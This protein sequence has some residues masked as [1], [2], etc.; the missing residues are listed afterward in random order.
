MLCGRMI[1]GIDKECIAIL[2]CNWLTWRK[3]AGFAVGLLSV[4]ALAEVWSETWLFG[5]GTNVESN[6]K[7][8]KQSL[9]SNYFN[10]VYSSPS[11]RPMFHST[12]VKLH[13]RTV[14]VNACLREM[15]RVLKWLQKEI[16]ERALTI[17]RTSVRGKQRARSPVATLAGAEGGNCIL[18]P[19]LL[20]EKSLAT[21]WP[22]HLLV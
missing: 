1:A 14:A 20:S 22:L 10:S 15:F 18:V 12:R 2:W 11:T 19:A 16:F 3:P 9:V 5:C 8:A 17:S 21:P 7:V 6:L 4:W 13:L